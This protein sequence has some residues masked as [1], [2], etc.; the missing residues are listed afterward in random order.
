MRHGVTQPSHNK[1]NQVLFSFTD[2]HTITARMN[3]VCIHPW[4]SRVRHMSSHV[5]T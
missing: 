1:S 5:Y 3:P 4:N 2:K